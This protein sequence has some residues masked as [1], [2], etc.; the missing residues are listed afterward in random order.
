MD[1]KKLEKLLN[2]LELAN[3]D[4]VSAEDFANIINTIIDGIDSFRKDIQ[5]K[6]IEHDSEM[7]DRVDNLTSLCEKQI[8][9]LRNIATGAISDFRQELKNNLASFKEDVRKEI[10]QIELTPGEDGEDAEF[11]EEI[12]DD[13]ALRVMG[14]LRDMWTV[15]LAKQVKEGIAK[16]VKDIKPVTTF[17]NQGGGIGAPFEVPIKAGTN[18]TVTKD[19]SGAYVISSTGTGGGSVD[20]VNGQTGTVVLTTTDIAE[21]TNLYYTAA[22]FNTAFATKSTTDLAE[23]TNLYFTNER[24]QDAIGNNLGTGLAYDDPTGAISLSFLGIQNLTDPNADR[25]WGW[26]DTDGAIKFITIGT[27]L[28]YDHATHTLSATGGGSGATTALDNLASVAINTSLVSDTDITDDLG[29]SLIRWNNIFGAHLGATGTR[30][31]DGW[32]TDLTVTNAIAGSITGNAATVTNGVYT[33]GADSVYLTPATAAST[34]Q[35]LDSDLTTIAG[36]TATTDNF[37]VSVASAWASRTPAQV[38]TTLGLVIG[39]DV[40]AYDADLTT[41]AGITPGTG[42]GTALAVNVGSAGAFVVNGGALGTPSSGDLTNC[43]FPT[44]NQNTTGS[45]ATLTTTR[46]IWGQNFNGSANVTGDITLGTA[47]ITM[48]GSIAATGARVTKGWFTDIESTNMPTV[49][50]T[51]ILTSLTAPQFT[52]IELGHASDTTLSRVS[53]GVVAIEGV[54]ILTVAGG[55]LTGSITLGENTGIA[56]DPAGS[57]DGKWTGITISGTAG[58]TV[59]FGD[60]V[61]LDAATSRWKLTD[62]DASATGGPVAVAMC[63]G[64]STDGNSINLL[65]YGQIR[66]DAKFPALTIGAPVY[67]GETAGAIQVAIP[68]GA[69]NVIRVVGFALT[70]DEILFCPSGDHQITVA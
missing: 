29:T 9:I 26:D 20:S 17:I 48:T 66:A 62:A 69:D 4:T 1:D 18:V 34:Y 52:T 53:A 37:I 51:A 38:R 33:T 67:L 14:S 56:L 24:A 2:A 36:L 5:S 11:T 10:D 45:A 31:T 16:A 15:E 65:L 21:G 54:N 55:T 49:G 43:T 40:Q 68:T 41:W 58:A 70:A 28:S 57:A 61:Y 47:N 60:L 42:V 35:P 12:K 7:M 44:L 3:R 27:N 39:T 19:A 50:G 25:L 23:G 13:I 32:F 46:T 22:R 63:L 59:A 6:M 8:E 64:S 30:F